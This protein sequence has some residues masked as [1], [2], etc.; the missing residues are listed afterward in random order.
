MSD[1]ILKL[2]PVKPSYKPSMESQEKARLFL[3]NSVKAQRIEI[4]QT[5]DVR[6]I[7]QG[8]N[9]ESLSC[10]VCG[11][12]IDMEIWQEHINIAYENQFT[13]LTFNTPC[14]Y[15]TTTLNDLIYNQPAGFARFALMISNPQTD[16]QNDEFNELQKIIG[17]DLK[18]I[19]A[20]Y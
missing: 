6:F 1:T 9:F 13:D 20:H 14:C 8:S 11:K 5:E 4:E 2:I 17:V 10:N 16:L 3:N 12:D 18:K 15:N 19:W 7:D